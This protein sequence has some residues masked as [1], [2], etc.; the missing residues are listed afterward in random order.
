MSD[1]ETECCD[2]CEYPKDQ[3]LCSS[4]DEQEQEEVNSDD[5][6][7]DQKNEEN[8]DDD[9]SDD[10][11]ADLVDEEEEEEKDEDEDN[12]D[13]VDF[14]EFTELDEP[15]KLH[16]DDRKF[17]QAALKEE[18]IIAKPICTSAGVLSGY[19]RD[20]FLK[21]CETWLLPR[22]ALNLLVLSCSNPGWIKLYIVKVATFLMGSTG[23]DKVIA[24]YDH[25]VKNKMSYA[26]DGQYFTCMK[27]MDT[28]SS[29]GV[30]KVCNNWWWQKNHD[31]DRKV[32][33]KESS[34][35]EEEKQTMME[36]YKLATDPNGN[37]AVEI[38][39]IFANPSA[40]CVDEDKRGKIVANVA[41]LHQCAGT[42][43]WHDLCQEVTDLTALSDPNHL[44]RQTDLWR[45]IDFLSRLSLLFS[46]KGWNPPSGS[47]HWKS[48]RANFFGPQRAVSQDQVH[49]EVVFDSFGEMFTV[50]INLPRTQCE[51]RQDE[52]LCLVTRK[53][54]HDMQTLH[55]LELPSSVSLST[56]GN[57]IDLSYHWGLHANYG[58]Y[59]TD[60]YCKGNTAWM[61]DFDNYG[62]RY[63]RYFKFV[64]P[65]TR[66]LVV[67][68]DEHW[69]VS[70]NCTVLTKIGDLVI[71]GVR[72]RDR[73]LPSASG[74]MNSFAYEVSR[75]GIVDISTH[76]NLCRFVEEHTGKDFTRRLRA[77]CSA[78]QTSAKVLCQE[79]QSMGYD[80]KFKKGNTASFLQ[81]LWRHAT[82]FVEE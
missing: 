23:V 70:C 26:F 39:C 37:V 21:Y 32:L 57:I 20:D 31:E 36:K 10:D 64:E 66:R 68:I 52:L 13:I 4:D 25:A 18:G 1:S 3:C 9:N 46:K 65:P 8:S 29:I 38:D 11:F 74:L 69:N 50:G 41:R 75:D 6:D 34:F 56:D 45:S 2:G 58:G 5:S 19:G 59:D 40:F 55:N 42:R 43:K 47:S 62:H 12:E 17:F 72:L 77:Q 49:F 16:F 60:T 51:S 48:A 76:L 73:L 63:G 7:Y 81:S 15:D 80:L 78:T 14:S 79:L 22:E 54:F 28:S 71:D 61:V 24:C 82:R 53:V 35:K 33:L 30:K 67:R 44:K 27:Y